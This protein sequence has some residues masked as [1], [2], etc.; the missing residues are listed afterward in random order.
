MEFKTGYLYVVDGARWVREAIYA[1]TRLRNLTQL[2]IA[3]ISTEIV[4]ELIEFQ[5]QTPNILLQIVPELKGSNFTSKIIGMLNSPFD[6]TF[7]MDSDTFVVSPIDGIFN[8]LQKYDMALTQEASGHTSIF[9]FQDDFKDLLIE[10]NSGVVLFKKSTNVIQILNSWKEATQQR[11]YTKDY[12][13]MPQFRNVLLNSINPP[14][15]YSLPENY[16]LHGLRTYKIIYGDIKIIHERFGT[17]WNS[18][19]EYMLNNEKMLILSERI[20]SSRQKRLFI[21]Y[22]NIVLSA[23]RLSIA[24]LIKRIKIKF[25]FPKTPK[26]LAFK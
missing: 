19:S 23:N 8:L 13:D 1:A 17:Y 12:F 18:Y 6:E 14:T 21:P 4:K 24:Y 26:N 22:F 3:I 7:F 9:D 5:E 2:P 10:Y 20:N 15:I 11:L 25:R 16:N